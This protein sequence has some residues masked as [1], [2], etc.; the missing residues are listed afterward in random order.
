MVAASAQFFTQLVVVLAAAHALG[1]LSDR[2]GFTRV[3]GEL[4]TG[5]VLGASVLGVLAPDVAYWLFGTGATEA[6]LGMAALG[7]VCLLGVAGLETD[8]AL[9]RRHAHTVA[10][11]TTFGVAVPFALGFGF[12]WVLPDALLVDPAS[13]YL[14]ALFVATALSVSAIPVIVRVFDDLGTLQTP[15][16]R[17]TVATAMVTDVVGWLLLGTVA[18]A[19]RTGRLDPA[20]L[21]RSALLLAAFLAVVVLV[22][23]PL[24]ILLFERLPGEEGRTAALLVTVVGAAAVT[25]A[26][27][28]EPVVGAFVAGA[29]LTR[30]TTEPGTREGF[31]S[32]TDVLLAPL[33]FGVAGLRADLGALLDPTVLLVA[34]GMLAVAVGGKFL[35]VFVGATLAGE[36][37]ANAVRMGVALNARGAVEIAVAT[38]GLELGLL[39][40]EL[41]TVVLV[42][43]VVTTTMTP[44][45]LRRV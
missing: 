5:F 36:S 17:V 3:V 35:G 23:R 42:V 43:A 39:S 44:P 6:L 1:A 30:V 41:Y 13:R 16:S 45:L 40:V 2:A 28:L 38:L 8:P 24:L 18:G 31:E 32:L 29:L 26:V 33:F 37:H 34:V 14:F 7:L 4:A 22:G 27:G 21:G 9:V 25:T 11:V 10:S 12:A 20:T 19:A 15:T